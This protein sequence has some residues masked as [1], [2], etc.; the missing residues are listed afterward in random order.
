MSGSQRG[1]YRIGKELLASVTT[2]SVKVTPKKGEEN[3]QIIFTVNG[4]EMGSMIYESEEHLVF[5]LVASENTAK[6]SDASYKVY[7]ATGW[8]H[9]EDDGTVTLRGVIAA[10]NPGLNPA[11]L[12][13]AIRQLEPALT[14]DFHRFRRLEVYDDNMNVF[15]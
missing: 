1:N 14:P 6:I 12:I 2:I 5:G 4:E 3:G 9:N 11:H 8:V 10:Q 7:G 15:R 13:A